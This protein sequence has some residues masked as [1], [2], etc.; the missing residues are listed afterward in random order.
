GVLRRERTRFQEIAALKD[1][2]AAEKI[3]LEEEIRSDYDFEEIIGDSPALKEAL[4]KVETV[5][6]TDSTVLILGETGTGK[7]LVARAIH[8]R[9]PRRER[10]LVKMNCASIP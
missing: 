7:E 8:D 6:A 5:A 3:Y 10:T 9:S 2:L 4:R 1:K